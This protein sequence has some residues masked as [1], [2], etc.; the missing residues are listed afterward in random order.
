M[1]KG[2]HLMNRRIL[3][4]RP[5]LA[6]ILLTVVGLTWMGCGPTLKGKSGDTVKEQEMGVGK[7]LYFDDILIPKELSLDEGASYVYET[8]QFKA[9]TMVLTKWRLE[10]KSLVDFF[11]YYM[12]KDN[13]KM[14]NSFQGKESVLNFSKPDKTCTFRIWEKWYGTTVVEIQVGPFGMK[15]M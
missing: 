15:K 5:T 11:T 14:V 13:W 9:G 6:L 4:I 1:L 2:G 8:P 12:E 3:R 7:Y 10:P